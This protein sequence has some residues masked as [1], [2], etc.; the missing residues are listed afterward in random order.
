[1]SQGGVDWRS[2]IRDAVENLKDI[3]RLKSFLNLL[4][5]SDGEGPSAPVVAQVPPKKER[6][7]GTCG[8]RPKRVATSPLNKEDFLRSSSGSSSDESERPMSGSDF[9]SESLTKRNGRKLRRAKKLKAASLSQPATILPSVLSD[10]LQSA[11]GASPS[12]AASISVKKGQL[13]SATGASPT[14]AASRSSANSQLLSAAGDSPTPVASRSSANS[15]LQSAAGASPSPAASVSVPAS[16]AQASQAK[17]SF[18]HAVRNG[19]AIAARAPG[20][21]SQGARVTR[22]KPLVLE[23]AKEEEK[24]NPLAIR[25]LLVACGNDTIKKT[26]VTKRGVVLVFPTSEEARAKLL[27]ARL[28]NVSLR[29]TRE[30]KAAASVKPAVIIV[31]VHPSISDEDIKGEIGRDVKR[32]VAA[33]LGGAATYKVKVHCR[34]EADRKAMLKD[35]VRMGHQKYRVVEYVTKRP[36]LQCFKCQSFGHVAAAC[37]AEQP[38]CRKCG[39]PHDGKTCEAEKPQCANCGGE[40]QASD[41]ACPRFAKAVADRET[42][43]ITYANMVKKSGDQID[44]IRLACCIARSISTT[45]IK[46]LQIGIPPTQLESDVSKYVADSV[47]QVYRV[48]VSGAHVHHIAYVSPAE[49]AKKRTQQPHA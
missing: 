8:A 24:A 37:S 15:Q 32:I 42:S 3:G 2:Q 16:Q 9:Y 10:L 43:T 13:Q 28:K 38:K 40:H 34:D 21:A 12:P 29:P 36:V 1:M 17:N 45:L 47:A 44:C 49:A 11:A 39:G 19:K 4:I 25:K 33:K 31:G 14:P 22:A 35:G 20:P 48:N 5:E 26:A 30:A 23:G 18:A 41:F 6:V 27:E 7:K 46:K